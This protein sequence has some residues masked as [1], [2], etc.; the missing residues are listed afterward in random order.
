MSSLSNWTNNN[1]ASVCA[2]VGGNPIW[3]TWD[4]NQRDLFI[5]NHEGDVVLYQNVTGGLPSNLESFV[6]NLIN[7]IPENPECIDGE[8][9][10]DN[11]C[12]PME[13]YEGQWY[14]M[15]IDCAEQ[16]GVPCDDGVY[17]APPEGVCCSTCVQY[18]DVNY[19]GELNVVDIVV[20]VSL[21]LNGNSYDEL[22]DVN[23]D[24]ALDVVDIVQLVSI[25]LN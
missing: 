23:E 16:M 3:N 19:D 15:I 5:L 13:C 24:G 25:I 7:E 22:G 4:A 14:E 20:I 6:I 10:N 18:G 12:M 21:I 8:I 17:V 11:P 2:D 9:N 1:D